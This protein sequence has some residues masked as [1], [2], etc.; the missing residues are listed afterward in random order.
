MR[1]IPRIPATPRHAILTGTL[2]GIPSTGQ[3]MSKRCSTRTISRISSSNRFL[4]R[5][6]PTRP[7]ADESPGEDLSD[8]DVNRGVSGVHGRLARIKI[9]IPAPL[10]EGLAGQ[11]NAYVDMKRVPGLDRLDAG[12]DRVGGAVEVGFEPCLEHRISRVR[13]INS[14]QAVLDDPQH[15]AIGKG[16]PPPEHLVECCRFTREIPQNPVVPSFRFRCRRAIQA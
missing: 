11:C 12:A 15:T 4:I 16:L 13:S 7:L 5:S 2:P 9:Q 6:I 1:L 8:I 3:S 10:V 14:R